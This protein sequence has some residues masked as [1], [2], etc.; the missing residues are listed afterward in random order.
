MRRPIDELSA[1]RQDKD[2]PYFAAW[3]EFDEPGHMPQTFITP[4]PADLPAGVLAIDYQRNDYVLLVEHRSRETLT[5]VVTLDDM[6][7]AR[8]ELAD[9]LVPLVGKIVAEA[10]G[11]EYDTSELV[12][13]MHNTATPCLFEATDVLFDVS[14]RGDAS[15]L[16]KLMMALEPVFERHGLRLRDESGQLLTDNRLGLAVAQFAKG[17]IRQHVHRRDGQPVP[18][19]IVIEM[20]QWLG[21]QEPG[22]AVERSQRFDEASQKVIVET[23]G[24]QEAFG[25]ALK[26]LT[27]RIL[28]LYVSQIFGPPKQ[29]DYVMEMPGVIVETNGQIASDTRS[30]LEVRSPAGVSL[31]LCH[32]MSLAGSTARSR[33]GDIGAPGAGRSRK[34]VAL[35]RTRARKPFSA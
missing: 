14:A 19:D 17:V 30:A 24:S 16:D 8:R 12:D 5:D 20:L 32:A 10:L 1:A 4:A 9:M 21:L 15:Q 18:E 25:E 26:P 2:H 33:T 35:R 27:A 23:F 29:F 7:V 6:H 22:A 11:D 13:W 3:G 31:W 28:G 34:D